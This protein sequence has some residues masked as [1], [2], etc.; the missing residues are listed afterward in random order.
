M[1]L[2]K[3]QLGPYEILNEIARG[4]MGIVYRARDTR[5]EKLVAVKVMLAGE[6][7]TAEMVKRFSREAGAARELSH[8]NIV[9]VLD[10]GADEGHHYFVMEYVDGRSLD[11][12]IDAGEITPRRSMELTRRIADAL[13]HAHERGIIHRDIKPSNILIDKD[14]EPHITDF[15]LAKNV[16]MTSKITKTGT[17]I[18]TPQYMPP[19]QAQGDLSQ[20][21][22][23]S[24]LYSLGVVLYE[25]FTYKTPFEAD[26]PSGIIYRL[27]TEDPVPPRRFNLAVDRSAET[28]C[29]KLLDKDPNRRYQTAGELLADVDCY[30]AGKPIAARPPSSFT[31]MIRKVRRG[32]GRIALAGV[33]T[34]L[35]MLVGIPLLSLIT[36]AHAQREI[37]EE[38]ARRQ[39]EYERIEAKRK[40]LSAGKERVGGLLQELIQ[41]PQNHERR[42]RILTRALRAAPEWPEF[43]MERAGAFFD[44]GFF[45]ESLEEYARL[46]Q[47]ELARPNESLHATFLRGL[48]RRECQGDAAGAREEFEAVVRREA[49]DAAPSAGSEGAGEGP[50]GHAAL[51][52]ALLAV[53]SGDASG[54]LATLEKT[55]K[56]READPLSD[57]VLPWEEAYCEGL[58]H[59]AAG[60]LV[61]ALESYQGAV[62]SKYRRPTF[63]LGLWG[64][65]RA[66]R[67]IAEKGE[68]KELPGRPVTGPQGEPLFTRKDPWEQ[69]LESLQEAV[70]R[71]P[72]FW[73]ARKDLRALLGL[74]V[75]KGA[76][77]SALKL[78]EALLARARLSLSEGLANDALEDLAAVAKLPRDAGGAPARDGAEPVWKREGRLLEGLALW[79]FLEDRTR[80]RALIEPLAK[81]TEYWPEQEK[82][83]KHLAERALAI[84]EDNYPDAPEKH[85]LT[86]LGRWAGSYLKALRLSRQKKTREALDEYG[87]FL[88][89]FGA[90]PPAL[91]ERAQ[92]RLEE[93]RRRRSDA[94]T[95]EFHEREAGKPE[96][97]DERSLREHAARELPALGEEQLKAEPV[98]QLRAR[99]VKARYEDAVEELADRVRRDLDVCLVVAPSF[100]RA[101]LLK[102]ELHLVLGETD[103]ARKVLA[104]AEGK[105]PAGHPATAEIKRRRAELEKKN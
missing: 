35:L 8:P 77:E 69:V 63:F 67:G 98:E 104:D 12:L 57:D 26:T 5:D 93:L 51:S 99:V 4:G 20:I 92:I 16:E 71:T 3:R 54:A 41:D 56:R 103:A 43:Q 42:V 38:R 73:P 48:I 37:D 17:C 96:I 55:R 19:E 68:P 105:A 11:Q 50:K 15:G 36:R 97:A 21:D 94:G 64:L 14:G 1:A 62:R 22:P 28:V 23:R 72:T 82:E 53:A 84:L 27:M 32:R 91:V 25:M 88:Q 30:L 101:A 46:A 9:A 80:A 74:R 76:G 83:P 34:G 100:P 39:A 6:D 24:D 45:A 102:A 31:R 52:A 81:D 95:A 79:T 70:V 87:H 66:A 18:G 2:T 85:L 40:G 90:W 44:W 49:A 33:A 59:E 60:E 7:A 65:A 10:E 47:N 89:E 58:A 61:K 75:E 29:L 78:P 13:A 86:G